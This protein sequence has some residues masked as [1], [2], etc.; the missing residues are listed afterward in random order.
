M[1]KTIFF[2]PLCV[3]GLKREFHVRRTAR[4]RYSID[5]SLF[6]TQG[7]LIL[8]DFAAAQQLAFT[9]NLERNA[10][11]YPEN[12][13]KAGDLH[14]AGLIDEALHLVLEAYREEINVSVMKE[15]LEHLKVNLGDKTIFDTLKRFSYHFPATSVYSGEEDLE[16]YLAASTDSIAHQEIILEELLLLLSLIHI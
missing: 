2:S 12:A 14:A 8:A 1:H 11:D 10:K 13:I 5:T 9:V 15:A 6:S 7:Q 4:D 16:T 3:K